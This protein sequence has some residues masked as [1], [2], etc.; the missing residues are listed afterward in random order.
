MTCED[1]TR[2]SLPLAERAARLRLIRT[3]GIGPVGFAALVERHGGAAAALDALAAAG[4]P[5]ADPAD[6]AAE[7]DRTE[8]LGGRH[9]FLGAPDYPALL[10]HLPD[11]PPVLVAI[12]DTALAGARCVGIVGAR[13][14]SAAG[15]RLAGELAEGLGEAG[16]TVASGMARG[17]DGAAHRGA[18]RT[19]TVACI[20]GG[21][22]SVYPP[23]H[24]E[25]QEMVAEQGLVLTEAA[26]GTEPRARHFPRR[27]RLIAG[28]SAGLVVVEA[29]PGSGS[30]ITAR[31]ALEAG[32]EV[33]A[34]PG[35]PRD[36]R[37]RGCNALIRDG[38][39]LVEESAHILAVLEPFAP[40]APRARR[41]A[42]VAPPE[43][44]L[45][46]ESAPPRPHMGP[47]GGLRALVSAT[48]VPVDELVRRS[49]LQAAAVH[50]MLVEME[51][52][53]RLVRHAGGRV[54]LEDSGR[55]V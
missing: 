29:T 25:L 35:H 21:L 45:P 31:I 22:D 34:V 6:V 52:E 37:A 13:N 2:E 4:K 24:R 3:D 5:L 18:L 43:S 1:V 26:L 8:E 53:G 27:N 16:W 19:G 36:P 41:R 48:P 46:L 33:M 49:G 30:L 11:A 51:L 42:G 44:F 47:D 50:A 7:L 32:R 38:A 54:A 28:I 10:A 40:A 12:G 9:L 17:I 14:A 15:M 20:A 23:D 39:T 55:G